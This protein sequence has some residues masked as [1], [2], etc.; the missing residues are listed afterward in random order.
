MK[1]VSFGDQSYDCHDISVYAKVIKDGN[2][3][4]RIDE[5]EFE[6]TCFILADMHIDADDDSLL[7]YDIQVLG[8]ASVDDI[9]PIVDNFILQCLIN[10]IE[11][12]AARERN[13]DQT[14]E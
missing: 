13:E 5:G 12:K 8:K 4:M 11:D 14:A 1:T 10:Q 6:G 7:V 3:I 2:Y 9:K